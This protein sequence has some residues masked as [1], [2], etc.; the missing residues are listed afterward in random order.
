SGTLMIIPRTNTAA[1]A[2]STSEINIEFGLSGSRACAEDTILYPSVTSPSTKPHAPNAIANL[3]L[4]ILA[5]T[6]VP[7]QAERLLPDTSDTQKKSARK[8][9]TDASML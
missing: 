7:I 6:A 1:V 5:P 9:G 8:T 4:T 2:N 3:L